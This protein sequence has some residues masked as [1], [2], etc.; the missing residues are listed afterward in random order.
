MADISL[1]LLIA[2]FIIASMA[3]AAMILF[4]GGREGRQAAGPRSASQ[5]LGYDVDAKTSVSLTLARYV[6][7]HPDAAQP[8]A[9]PFLLLTGRDLAMYRRKGMPVVLTVPW[10]K[11][12]N[13]SRLSA[14]Q[15]GMAAASV[16][17]LA[18]GVLDDLAPDATFARVRFEDERGWWQNVVFELAPTFEDL[19]FEELNGTWALARADAA[20]VEEPPKA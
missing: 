18:P 13:I 10:A 14:A 19:Q 16:R 6:G 20:P 3:V 9:Q 2:P 11:V 8:I 12:D 7:G 5:T 1:P 15:M 4:T 17:G